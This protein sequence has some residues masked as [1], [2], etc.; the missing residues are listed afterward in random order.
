MN[1][2][3]RK[4]AAEFVGTFWLMFAGTGA[5]VV[6]DLTGGGVTHVGIALAF[7]MAILVMIYAVGDVSGA[8]FNPA[9]T[10]GFVVSGRLESGK[11][12][13]YLCGQFLGALAGTGVLRLLFPQ[14]PNLG[15]TMPLGPVM[16]SLVLEAIMTGLLM[17]VILSVSIGAKE[18]GITAG[19]AIGTVI[20]M[21]AM[22]GGPVSGA[23]MNPARSFA[24]AVISGHTA[25]LWIYFVGPILGALAAVPLCRVIRGPECCSSTA[26]KQ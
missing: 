11:L 19:L 20:A 21:E 4:A 3:F 15:T 14:H 26:A 25:A 12:V 9:V 22:F 7:G 6:N 2:T 23:S 1:D 10:I 16:Q 5:I 13:P 24:P 8:H 18:K 17:F